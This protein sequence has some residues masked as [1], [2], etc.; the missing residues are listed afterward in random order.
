MPRA[1]LLVV[2]A[3]LAPQVATAHVVRHS[4]I[5]EA[6]RGAW[7][8]VETD[9]KDDKSVITLSAKA[10]V[11]PAGSCMVDY[12]TSPS[13]PT[14]S[15]CMRRSRDSIVWLVDA[16]VQCQLGRFAPT[17]GSERMNLWYLPVQRD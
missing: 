12:V 13:R 1:F 2:I 6:Y 14:P 5:P 3:A 10:Y 17:K 7:A 4:S 15:C 16:A 8:P 9:C 11:G